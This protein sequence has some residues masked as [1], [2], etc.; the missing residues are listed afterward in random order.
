M[1]KICIPSIPKEQGGSGTFRKLWR[2][3]LTE[4]KIEWTDDINAEYDILFVNAWQTRYKAVYEQKKRLPQLR[5]VQR[6]DGAGRDYGRTDNADL[7][8]LAVNTVTD[9]TIF[10]SDYSR[11]STMEKHSIIRLDGETVYNPVDISHY[12][13]QGQRYN[14]PDAK[15]PRVLTVSWSANH[16]KGAWRIPLIASLNPDIEFLYAGRT[17]FD[18]PPPNIRHLGKVP[19]DELPDLMRSVDVFLNLSLYD[20]CPNVVI[21]ALAS[22]LPVLYVS[23]GGTPEL[24]GD[25]AGLVIRNDE[26]FRPQFNEIMANLSTY[27]TNARQHAETNFS[28]D[29]IFSRYLDIINKSRRRPMPSA[30][31]HGVSLML[32][33][34]RWIQDKIV[35]YRD[36]WPF[37]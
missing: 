7:I 23:S 19:H 5:V 10:Q 28:R 33:K 32:M 27:Q 29:V 8:Q 12:T 26:N 17:T 2:T 6:V 24:V 20:P 35:N 30:T 1:T 31:Q 22:G 13:P 21:E 9:T 11:H 18:N 14:L 16:N 3:W 4:N 37:S 25:D 36:W 34:W 15:T